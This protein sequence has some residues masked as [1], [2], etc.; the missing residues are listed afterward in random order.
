MQC[1]LYCETLYT[2]EYGGIFERG[3]KEYTLDD[4]HSLALD[5]LD[6]YTCLKKSDVV[7]P[8]EGEEESSSDEDDDNDDS[9]DGESEEEG[10]DGSDEEQPVTE[11][12]S[13][14][15]EESLLVGPPP[16]E[17]TTVDIDKESEAHAK[18]QEYLGVSTIDSKASP[19]DAMRTP[20]PGEALAQF[21]NRTREYW[22]S[23]AFAASEE[24]GKQLRRGGFSMA[25]D[26][27]TEYKPTLEQIEKI[28]AEAGLD[29]EEIKR[30]AV[31]GPSSAQSTS[32]NRR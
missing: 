21:Y 26:R 29:E 25:Q 9:S 22:S 16:E 31:A 6:R 7:I 30:G 8:T 3:S 24:R 14:V 27:Y 11:T 5:K 32:R 10:A 20:L 23:K 1:L 18:A 13:K 28:L 19:E 4:F 15:P 2:C 12:V 17:P